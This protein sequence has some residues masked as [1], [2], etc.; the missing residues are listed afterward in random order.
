MGRIVMRPFFVAI[1]GAF[2]N[3]TGYNT[4]ELWYNTV[5]ACTT[6]SENE[7]MTLNGGS[8]RLIAPHG[9]EL[10][11]CL[12]DA[13]NLDALRERAAA[14][15]VALSDVALSDLEL[16]ATGVLSP[17]TGFMNSQEYRAVV[18]DMN[19]PGGLPWTI[20]ITLPVDSETAA[21]LR[22]GQDVALADGSGK[23]IGLLELTEKFPYDRQVEA[24]VYR[25]TDPASRRCPSLCLR[26]RVPGWPSLGL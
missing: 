1:N 11:D 8:P 20:P 7:C 18:H 16:I 17:L 19:L 13:S 22:V 14:P 26:R 12:C 23:V 9:G 2:R 10:V 25:T 15:T 5:P 6:A 4:C 24:K 21:S 3:K